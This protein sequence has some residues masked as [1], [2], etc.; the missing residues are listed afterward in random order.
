[1]RV[2]KYHNPA[3][4]KGLSDNESAVER[5]FADVLVGVLFDMGSYLLKI[6]ISIFSHISYRNITRKI[7]CVFA[8]S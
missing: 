3:K 5:L 6:P 7:V 2:S 8:D 4:I 1:M